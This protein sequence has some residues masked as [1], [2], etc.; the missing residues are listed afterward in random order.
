MNGKPPWENL[1]DIEIQKIV[2][3]DPAQATHQAAECSS[4]FAIEE[5]L[6]YLNT[7]EPN[8]Q[9][10]IEEVVK[11]IDRIDWGQD[12]LS[13][14]G[15]VFLNTAKLWRLKWS[16]LLCENDATEEQPTTEEIWEVLVDLSR[17]TTDY[18][19][20]EALY[21]APELLIFPRIKRQPHRNLVEYKEIST[22]EEIES[23]A[24]AE[25]P[26]EDAVDL[27]KY[28][29][30]RSGLDE[31]RSRER[32]QGEIGLHLVA[33]KL[34]EGNEVR[35]FMAALFA[36]TKIEMLQDEFYTEIFLQ[37]RTIQ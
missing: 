20:I 31:A 24:H 30:K 16:L 13:H 21:D 23:I 28:L 2:P 3:Y 1:P 10:S 9:F 22:L 7:L 35:A 11:R 19:R 26:Q 32:T 5:L 8:E 17:K 12:N 18:T 15:D 37:C 14:A 6:V 25:T 36:G 34:F 4:T 29:Q 33:E 27:M